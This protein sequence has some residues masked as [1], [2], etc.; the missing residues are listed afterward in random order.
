MATMVTLLAEPSIKRLRSLIRH[1]EDVQQDCQILGG[2][3]IERGEPDLGRMLIANGL[4]HDASKFTGI[5]WDHLDSK[6]DPLFEEAWLH[7]V[8]GNAHHPEYWG[9]GGIHR[10]P[11][12]YVAEAVADWHAR[13]TE[14]GSSLRDWIDR[15]AMRKFSFGPHDEVGR[16]V[17]DFVDLL[18]EHWN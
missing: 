3:L 6:Q 2:R 1:V 8:H 14:F 17:A 18:L 7:H 11:R 13:S 12:V 15:E 16:Q 4:S 5:E 10:M 9:D